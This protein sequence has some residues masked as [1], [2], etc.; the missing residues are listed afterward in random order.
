MKSKEFIEEIKGKTTEELT[1]TLAEEVKNLDKMKL[2]HSVSPMSN[3][4]QIKV[5]RKNIARIKTELR[6]RELNN[7]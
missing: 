5:A 2:N 3:P 4:M 7:N 6:N 1:N